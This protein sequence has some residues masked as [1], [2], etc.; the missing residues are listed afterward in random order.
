MIFFSAFLALLALIKNAA[1]TLP[2]IIGLGLCA[3]RRGFAA[4]YLHTA[5]PFFKINLILAICAAIYFPLTYFSQI[6]H[7]QTGFKAIWQPLFQLPGLP[8]STSFLAWLSGICFI[9]M[10]GRYLPLSPQSGDSYSLKYLKLTLI[11]CAMAA[12]CFFAP[13]CLNSWPFA[14]LPEGLTMDR[15]VFAI[16]RNA[17][18]HFFMACGAGGALILFIITFNYRNILPQIPR[19]FAAWAAI[20]YLTYVLQTWGIIIGMLANRSLSGGLA[21]YNA[22]IIQMVWL[23]S[24]IICWGL[25]ATKLAPF[26]LMGRYGFGLLILYVLTPAL[27]NLYI[28]IF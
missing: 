25:A 21:S 14:G 28:H 27:F 1:G 8:W 24:A 16:L 22:L 15:A 5:K 26:K 3:G 18:R 19:W 17:M 11:Y 6:I 20:G 23:T 12:L 9:A 4:Q 2:F 10:A 7:Y 13:F